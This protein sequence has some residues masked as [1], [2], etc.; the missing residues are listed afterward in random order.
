MNKIQT[1]DFRMFGTTNDCMNEYMAKWEH[2]LA[3]VQLKNRL[4]QNI[5]AVKELD[6]KKTSTV[7]NPVTLNKEKTKDLL[8]DKIEILAGIASSYA[9]AK[10]LK[11]LKQKVKLYTK[12]LAKKRE[13]EIEPK[14]SSFLS[15]LRELLPELA[16]YALTEE[17]IVEAE[18]IRN[19]FAALVGAPRTLIVQGSSAN[20]QM[21]VLIA[22]TLRFLNEQLDNLMLR[23][24]S[25]SPEFF[26]AYLQA[27]I[28][29]EPATQSRTKPDDES[30]AI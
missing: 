13:M 2:I 29:V 17:M 25:I 16:D 7:S 10:D 20:N 21:D 24:R 1:K 11:E 6:L 23:F 30:P 19:Q 26:N 27:R 5:L 3:I 18:T 28:I 14:A 9:E 22:E 12:G 4:Q 15:I 8:A